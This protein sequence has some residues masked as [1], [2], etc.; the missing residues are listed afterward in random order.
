MMRLIER[1]S[2]WR[3]VLAPR[4]EHVAGDRERA[5]DLVAAG[6][7]ITRDL[8]VR[9]AAA[10]TVEQVRTK[11]CADSLARRQR[12]VGL[13]ERPLTRLAPIPTLAPPQKRHPTGDR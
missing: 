2:T 6:V 13:S 4:D 10:T 11:P 5:V 1:Q 8:G 12:R 9:A 3:P 7:L